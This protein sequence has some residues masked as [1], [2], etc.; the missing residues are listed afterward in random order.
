[1]DGVSWVENAYEL[2]TDPG[3]WY[4]N[5]ATGYL[6]YIPR[7]G[8]NMATATVVLPKVEQ[9]IN[10][11][12]SSLTTPIHNIIFSGITFEYATWLLPSTSAGYADNQ[13]GIMWASETAPL[14]TQANVSF[15]TCNN[16]QLLNNTFIHLGGAAV[17]IGGGAQSNSIIGNH[18][19]DVSGGGITLGE[20]TDYA[21]TNASQ[22]TNGNSISNNYI[23]RVGLEYED[24]IAI[25]VGYAENTTISYNNLGNTPYTGISVGW[26]WGTNSYAQNNLVF[27]NF[28]SDIMQT[29]SDGGS[30]YSL[31]AQ[32]SSQ[33]YNNYF[34][35]SCDEG[36]YW[37][38]GTTNYT[39]SNNVVDN[40][41]HFW[42]YI[43][44]NTIQ[45]N[46]ANGNFTNNANVENNG[47]NCIIENTTVVSGE[48]WPSAAQTV[49]ANAGLQPGYTGLESAQTE[50]ND[51]DA[52]CVYTGSSWTYS[53][54]RGLGEYND[55][56]HYT[57][58]NGD[59]VTYT[60][61]GSGISVVSELDSGY[62]N[63]DIYLDGVFQQTYNCASSSARVPEATI[64]TASNLIPATHTVKVVKDNGTY[65]VVDAFVVTRPPEV[66]VND[67]VPTYDHV[68]S[69]WS[70]SNGRGRGELDDD[71]HYTETNGEYVQYTFTGTGITP[72][73]ETDVS[74][75]D[76]DVYLDGVFQTTVHCLGSTCLT[77]Q[78]LYSVTG[79][80]YG[81]HSIKLVKDNGSF[82]VLDGFAL[83]AGGAS[84][85]TNGMTSGNRSDAMTTDG[86][87]YSGGGFD[88]D[89]YSLSSTLLGSSLSW[90]GLVFNFLPANTSN[91]ASNETITLPAGHFSTLSLLAD[92]VNGNQTSQTF[93]VNYTNGTH[94]TF[95]QSMSDWGQ[96]PAGYSGEATAA[97]MSYRDQSNGTIESG[98]YYLHGYSF[99]INGSLTV[100]SIVLPAN[101]NVVV[102]AIDLSGAPVANGLTASGCNINDATVTDGTTFSG[103]GIDG[104]GD[105]YSATQLGSTLSWNG[106]S[107]TLPAANGANGASNKTITLPSGMFSSISLL[108]TGVNGNQ[109]AQ[110]FKVN[111]TNGTNATF[112]QSLSD[113]SAPQGYSGESTAL[114]MTRS[115]HSDG[116]FHSGPAYLYGYTF[117]LNNTLTVQSIVLPANSD[118]VV[119]GIDLQ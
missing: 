81:S 59:Y 35:N 5:Q 83:P 85:T 55:D 30:F 56:L 47:T 41:S 58:N 108:A 95:T 45:N 69:D 63:V 91:G 104:G 72:L 62:G 94:S 102:V 109:T 75:G 84:A 27:N 4:L 26:G 92:A 90:N 34:K 32:P 114:T 111:Y 49:I 29:L 117:P 119:I 15:E 25:W 43:W 76:V 6:Y 19:E 46:T 74:S 100:S 38:E 112:T 36:I 67:T 14:K 39:A 99:A 44:T 113:W 3:M 17:N 11:S 23:N 86:T 9:L 105:A 61:Y 96:T 66:L 37:D 20:V 50:I 51:T 98:T 33:V 97:T 78:R 2:L 8:E 60:F 16:I 13:G 79:L 65:M 48:S 31:S 93:T 18:I 116:S 42:V 53:P 1:M 64:F 103:G 54:S 71:V 70:Y 57:T 28:V 110:T 82:M 68:P 77:Q 73:L 106:L 40:P 21:T 89:G 7:S 12:G 52:A 22:K 107:F 10:A 88:G 24:A 118:V 101:S 87:S 115:N 80:P